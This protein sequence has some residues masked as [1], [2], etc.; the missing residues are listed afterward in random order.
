MLSLHA[1]LPIF[2]VALGDAAA[3][4]SQVRIALDELVERGDLAGRRRAI[5]HDRI[6]DQ[7]DVGRILED[8]VTIRVTVD[9]P[10]VRQAE[11]GGASGRERGCQYVWISEVAVA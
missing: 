10:G 2:P 4:R 6:V 7:R 9:G 1:A 3:A 5:A 8:P 11:N